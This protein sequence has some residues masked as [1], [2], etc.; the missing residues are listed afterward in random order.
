[1]ITERAGRMNTVSRGMQ[2]SA[3]LLAA[4]VITTGPVF[5]QDVPVT[6]KQ[7]GLTVVNAGAEP[8][9]QL[10]Y[11]FSPGEF[12]HYE[13]VTSH[14]VD[15][16][17]DGGKETVQTDATSH[18]NVRVV[19]VSNDGSAVLEPMVKKT[20]MRAAFNG[21]APIVY[22][23]DSKDPPQ[24]QFEK[25]AKT[26][27]RPLTRTTFASNGE[28]IKV[29]PLSGAPDTAVEVANK[30]DFAMNSLMI[31]P[32]QPVG[33]GAIWRERFP[34]KVGPENSRV[35]PPVTLQR[36]YQL[37]KLEGGIATISLRTATLTPLDNPQI[38][39]ELLSR[40]VKGTITFD[41]NRGVI[42]SQS[43]VA[44]GKVVGAFGPK[45]AMK[46]VLETKERLVPQT[47]GVQPATL[48]QI[49][50]AQ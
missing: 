26:I 1:M 14:A 17:F 49:G 5:G 30:S 32:K 39:A 21:L 29:V 7:F 33:V 46:S 47:E 25:I 8:Q 23:S 44:G 19:S 31:L 40:Q 38:E 48:K 3:A 6:P 22:D 18:R 43:S 4:L 13:V 10:I 37:V 20:V 15:T 34:V 42:L 16:E 9:Q 11:K 24:L 35:A 2:N 50:A 28:M 27:G 12:V 36:E 41:V 45:T